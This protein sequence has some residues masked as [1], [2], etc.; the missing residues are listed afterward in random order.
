M[1]FPS[2]REI[3]A[4]RFYRS[5]TLFVVMH[6]AVHRFLSSYRK[7]RTTVPMTWHALCP[8]EAAFTFPETSAS[9]EHPLQMSRDAAVTLI[10]CLWGIFL[11]DHLYFLLTS[12]NE[13]YSKGAMFKF[14]AVDWVA[15]LNPLQSCLISMSSLGL[16]PLYDMSN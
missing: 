8:L 14:L 9:G 13:I 10:N 11:L 1:T 6:V 7:T 4:L 2:A 15:H 3:I 5:L 12:V 16:V